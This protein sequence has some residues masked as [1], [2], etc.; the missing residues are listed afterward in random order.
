MIAQGGSVFPFVLLDLAVAVSEV[1]AWVKVEVR[2]RVL[3]GPLPPTIVVL[4]TLKWL[5]M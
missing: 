5:S 1:E 4:L 3:A 2:V